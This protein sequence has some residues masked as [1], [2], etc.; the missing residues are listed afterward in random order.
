MTLCPTVQN[1]S[2]ANIAQMFYFVKHKKLNLA[3]RVE[4]AKP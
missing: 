4:Q 3:I 2:D 1:H